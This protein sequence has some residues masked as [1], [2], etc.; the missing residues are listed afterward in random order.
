ML[1]RGCR[2]GFVL[3]L[4]L[5][6]SLAPPNAPGQLAKEYDL[7]AAFLFNFARFVEWPPAAFVSTEELFIIGVLGD[8]PFGATLD[9]VVRNE[10]AVR[11]KLVVRRYQNVE[12]IK[13]CQILFIGKSE[14]ANAE[15]ILN[16]L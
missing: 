14:N 12:D 13:N 1:S 11:R 2:T 5:A 8:D 10:T 3:A 15:K 9:E 4:A 7:K 6:F 16:A